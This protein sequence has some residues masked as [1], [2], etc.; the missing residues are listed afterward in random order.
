M[1]FTFIYE[2]RRLLT[3]K[4]KQTP[5]RSQL[6]ITN[7]I[8]E[9]VVIRICENRISI[10][11]KF[12]SSSHQDRSRGSK[13]RPKHQPYSSER[14]KKSKIFWGYYRR[15][16]DL[17][18]LNITAKTLEITEHI[19]IL[20]KMQTHKI[21][22]HKQA[23]LHTHIHTHACANKDSASKYKSVETAALQRH[24]HLD[25]PAKNWKN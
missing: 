16:L 22:T 10:Q 23:Q 9:R 4:Q 3:T 17:N 24:P 13:T 25:L 19:Y 1:T 8:Q 20:T 12:Q 7:S 2:H 21:T 18:L 6:L 14:I 11:E 5:N 15:L